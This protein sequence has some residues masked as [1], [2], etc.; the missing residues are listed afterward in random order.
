M[1]QLFNQLVNT[2]SDTSIEFSGLKGITIAQWLLESGRGT[3]RLAS[4]HLN[5]GGLKWRSGMER[6]SATTDTL[7]FRC[8]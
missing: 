7:L 5:F 1:S 2:Y 8:R 3:S 6:S 4:E